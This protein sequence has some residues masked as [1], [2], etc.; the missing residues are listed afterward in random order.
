MDSPPD[1]PRYIN[2]SCDMA[3]L[4]RNYY[5]NLQQ[6]DLHPPDTRQ[7]AINNVLSFVSVNLPEEEKEKLDQ[8]ISLE[9]I[10]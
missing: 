4:A 1:A 10:T 6:K 8:L 7:D 2:R 5:E 9:E 3:E